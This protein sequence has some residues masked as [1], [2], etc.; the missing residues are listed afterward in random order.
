MANENVQIPFKLFLMMGDYVQNHY[1]SN[2]TDTYNYIC[3][4]YEEKKEARFRH[5]LYKIYKTSSVP[6][7]T[8]EVARHMYLDRIGMR[9]KY[10][11]SS[12]QDWN[13]SDADGPPD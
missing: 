6:P 9:E 4:C 5:V 8:R 12:E 11:W 3:R 13:L 7:E 2:M 10:R 1:D